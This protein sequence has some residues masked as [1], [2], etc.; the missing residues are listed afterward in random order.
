MKI[1]FP[2]NVYSAIL[3]LALPDVYKN[4]ILIGPSSTIVKDIEEDKTDIGLIPSCDLIQHADLFVSRKIALSFDGML[5][6]AYLYF[7]PEQKD[8]NTIHLRGDVSTNEIILTKIIFR[9]RFDVEVEAILDTEKLEFNEKN[10]LIVGQ[11]NEDYM[12]RFNGLSFADQVA[13]FLD[14]PYV[15]FV[16]VSKNENRIKEFNSIVTELDKKVEDNI[17]EYLSKMNLSSVQSDFISDNL[18]TVYFQMTDIEK[19]G[20]E[21]LYKLPFYHGMTKDMFGVKFVL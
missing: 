10:Y 16:V 17:Q 6:N 14:Y 15:N 11:E 18:K 20:L 21:E 2:S 13:E 8:I 12:I 5:S 4:K 7:T 9:E 3:A 1:T 19:F